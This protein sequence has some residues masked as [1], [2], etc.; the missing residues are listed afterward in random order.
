MSYDHPASIVCT[1][2][3]Y[4][5]AHCTCLKKEYSD[6]LMYNFFSGICEDTLR[7]FMFNFMAAVLI[8]E[9]LSGI[10]LIIQTSA[11]EVVA[12]AMPPSRGRIPF[13]YMASRDEV[14]IGVS[15]QPVDGRQRQKKL[16]SP[17]VTLSSTHPPISAPSYSSMP[18]AL[19]L[20]IYSSDLSLPL[21]HHDRRLAMSA[22]AHVDADA[23][24]AA[25][26]SSAAPSGLVQPP[27]SPH[28][29]KSTCQ[30]FGIF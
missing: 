2:I 11:L 28:N 12:L 4:S 27:V 9:F 17:T 10:N 6:R 3:I 15:V 7:N 23:P 25:S 14:L 22:P 21:V 5:S 19:D 20:A 26:N 29:G 13:H 1:N 24:D 30:S 16:Y 8:L 18:G